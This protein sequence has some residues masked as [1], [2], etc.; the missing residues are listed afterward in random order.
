[1]RTLTGGLRLAIVGGMTLQELLKQHGIT[2]IK[3]LAERTGLSSQH[4]WNLWHAQVGI[5]TDMLKRLH[6]R[7]Q[8]PLEELIQID[9]I[10]VPK[11]KPRKRRQR[12]AKP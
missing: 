11:R 6:Q 3:E 5:G 2:R 7:L 10:S 1:M 12:R 4:A 9:P 8:I